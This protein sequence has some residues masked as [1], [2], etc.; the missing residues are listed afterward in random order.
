MD[1]SQ[2]TLSSG[3]EPES[4][5]P[6]RWRASN[7]MLRMIRPVG[8]S[9]DIS[10]PPPN[11]R[12]SLNA[13]V[14]QRSLDHARTAEVEQLRS[15]NHSLIARLASLEASQ[16]DSQ[17]SVSGG[18]SRH[19]SSSSPANMEQRPPAGDACSS[20]RPNRG[21]A[22]LAPRYNLSTLA[23]DSVTGG[24]AA[25]VLSSMRLP[26][27]LAGA[28]AAPGAARP[29]MLG[30]ESSASGVGGGSGGAGLTPRRPGSRLRRMLSSGRF[31]NKMSGRLSQSG[32]PGGPHRSG[33]FSLGSNAPGRL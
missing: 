18:R 27:H 7:T 33:R 8:A 1:A 11:A 2:L 20:R 23:E 22:E 19:N 24:D 6:K 29:P 21:S 30:G 25:G 28:A 12:R 5:E 26:T 15:E 32:K 4:T 31:D 9:V 17:E 14:E 10:L 3:G 16:R 13:E